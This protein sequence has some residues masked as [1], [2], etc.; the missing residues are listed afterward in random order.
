MFLAYGRSTFSPCK[1]CHHCT[2]LAIDHGS[3]NN[4]NAIG[5]TEDAE[6]FS[7]SYRSRFHLGSHT[8]IWKA[9]APSHHQGVS[10][11]CHLATHGQQVCFGPRDPI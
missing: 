7:V 11:I 1:D 9:Q 6:F 10:H 3:Y 2:I 4:G 8:L 5:W